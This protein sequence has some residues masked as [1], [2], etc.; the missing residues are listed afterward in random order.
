MS[1]KGTTCPNCGASI[2]C[3]CQ[4]RTAK[5]GT[6]GCQQCIAA[7]EKQRVPPVARPLKK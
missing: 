6:K 5:N 3:G 4:R 2:K 7:L 1:T